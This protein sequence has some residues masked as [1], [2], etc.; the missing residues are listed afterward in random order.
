MGKC[1]NRICFSAAIVILFKNITIIDIKVNSSFFLI[2]QIIKSRGLE[3]VNFCYPQRSLFKN[4]GASYTLIKILGFHCNDIRK[5]LKPL[6]QGN[7]S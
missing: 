1:L 7:K 2:T 5:T 6:M 4:V 3:I